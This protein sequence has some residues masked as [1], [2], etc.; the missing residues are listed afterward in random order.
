MAAIVPNP[1]NVCPSACD[2]LPDC[3][4]DAQV[5]ECTPPMGTD[6]AEAHCSDTAGQPH[7]LLVDDNETFRSTLALALARRG[8]RVLQAADVA[9]ALVLAGRHRPRFAVL[10]LNLGSEFGLALIPRL[11]EQ[12]DT[13]IVVLTGYASIATAV[14]A[15]RLGAVHYLSKPADVEDVVASF[16]R[17][18][19]DSSTPLA[20]RPMSLSQLEWEH[21]QRALL[22]HDGNVSATARSLGMHR[23]SLQRKLRKHARW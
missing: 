12:S 10:D 22:D 23:R 5:G 20:S 16:D 7:L 4:M 1:E 18:A 11:I 15:I 9:S 13:R 3:R 6:M 2:N 21:L 8:Y 14:E 19:G 17:L